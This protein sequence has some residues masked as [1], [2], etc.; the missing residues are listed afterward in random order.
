MERLPPGG[1]QTAAA[2]HGL[3]PSDSPGRA[4][5]S[6]AGLPPAPGLACQVT[7]LFPD[8]CPEGSVHAHK[9]QFHQACGEEGGT[10]HPEK[11]VSEDHGSPSLWTALADEASLDLS[12]GFPQSS[13]GKE[14]ACNAGDPGSI[15]ELGR[16]PGEGIGYPLQCSWA[17]LVVQLVKN[18]PA[19]RETGVLSLGWEGP[20]EKGKAT[21]SSIL[22]R[23]FHGLY[24][25]WGR[26]E[27]DTTERLS[28]SATYQ[29]CDLGQVT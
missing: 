4:R 27:S 14:S 20:L 21:H 1:T 23:E 17:S 16:S 19:M 15:P 12:P 7:Q 6:L 11:G 22:P 2:L 9:T 13:V 3:P 24:S 28:L 5:G 26:K 10:P 29:L 25:P 18:P 8:G